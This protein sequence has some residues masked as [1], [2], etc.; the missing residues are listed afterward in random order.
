MQHSQAEPKGPMTQEEK[1]HAA[2]IAE[3]INTKR[4]SQDNHVTDQDL[5]QDDSAVAKR[6]AEIANARRK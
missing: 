5:S 6:V 1:T 2:K 4:S 3:A